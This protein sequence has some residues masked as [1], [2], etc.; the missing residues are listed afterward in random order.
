MGSF[1]VVVAA[2]TD[3]YEIVNCMSMFRPL[4]LREDMMN[5]ERRPLVADGASRA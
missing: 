2:R 5:L 1:V 3:G 4:A